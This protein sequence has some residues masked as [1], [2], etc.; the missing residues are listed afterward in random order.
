MIERLSGRRAFER[1]RAEGV[2]RG[3][4]PLR[5]VS[6]FESPPA[7]DDDEPQSARI[8]YAIPRS[9]GSAV[10]R[11]RVRRRLR[12][13]LAEIDADCEALPPPGDHLIRV[14]G[15]LEHW[16]HAVLRRTM[17]ELLDAGATR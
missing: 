6:R 13:V 16:S 15:S 3:R 1:L 5:L 4:G 8:A 12:A 2:R 7:S 17:I 14:T 10:E 9:V 11:N